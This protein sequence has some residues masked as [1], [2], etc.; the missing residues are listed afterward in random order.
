MLTGTFWFSAVLEAER[1]LHRSVGEPAEAAPQAA[2]PAV[3]DAPA[4]PEPEGQSTA[5]FDAAEAFV[6]EEGAPTQVGSNPY[7]QSGLAHAARPYETDQSGRCELLFEFRKLTATSYE[8][9]CLKG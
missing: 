7:C 5:P 3:E 8:A 9:C 2:E 6:A 1:I 4:P